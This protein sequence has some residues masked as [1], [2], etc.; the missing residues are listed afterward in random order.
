M[1]GVFA[2]TV[3][4][5]AP[6][7]EALMDQAAAAGV[8][9]LELSAGMSCPTA[10]PELQA[11][12]VRQV[13]ASGMR[14]R[15]HNYFPPPAEP[16][17]LNLA[18]NDA[19]VLEASLA[20]CRRA[21]HLC[22]ALGIPYYSVHAGF[23]VHAAPQDLG[24]PLHALPRIPAAQAR[25]IFVQSVQG[26]AREA[27][28]LGLELALENNVVEASN[29]LPGEPLLLGGD[30]QEL[31][32]LL[33]AIA[34]PNV[35]LLLDLGHLHVSARTMG[36]AM[37]TAVGLL[38]PHVR[39]V[40]VSQN[41]GLADRHL[42]LPPDGGWFRRLAHLLPAEVDLVLEAW[43]VPLQEIRPQLDLMEAMF[44]SGHRPWNEREQS[45]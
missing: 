5:A 20:L 16:F 35:R 30:P 12:L 32:L 23:C 21:L 17:V 3:C 37:E 33:E 11:A 45:L 22:A 24:R 26:L 9:C 19:A 2:S 4:F 31:L 18:S 7:L 15:L 34:A 38:A 43:R 8:S 42:P 40:H 14:L 36:F 41:D 44:R 1:C 10:L 29:F 6:T 28:A 13:E 39:V 25:D 27:A